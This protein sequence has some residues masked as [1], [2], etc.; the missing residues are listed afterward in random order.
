VRR[1]VRTAF[2][3]QHL[4]WTTERMYLFDG[5]FG[6]VVGNGKVHFYRGGYGLRV[7]TSVSPPPR[8]GLLSCP[9]SY[10]ELDLEALSSRSWILV[11]TVTKTSSGSLPV[12][13]SVCAS[14]FNILYWVKCTR[15]RMS[16]ITVR[17]RSFPGID[18]ESETEV[19]CP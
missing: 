7:E 13:K 16:L 15:I 2:P 11:L 19:P 10:L 5:K 3:R 6:D 4:V 9:T 18:K 1:W 14:S 12:T 8:T 17:H